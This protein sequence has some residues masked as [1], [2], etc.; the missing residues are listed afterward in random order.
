[1]LPPPTHPSNLDPPALCSP[2]DFHFVI[3]AFRLIGAWRPVEDM[4]EEFRFK[5]HRCRAGQSCPIGEEGAVRGG[6]FWGGGN[7]RSAPYSRA[8]CLKPHTLLSTWPAC[9]PMQQW[10]QL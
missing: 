9:G 2:Q 8:L 1:M 3:G 6:R 4:V 7:S 10:R 5:L